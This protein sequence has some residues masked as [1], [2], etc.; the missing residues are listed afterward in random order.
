MHSKSGYIEISK[1]MHATMY[2]K[3]IKFQQK[4]LV[5]R[6]DATLRP[7]FTSGSNENLSYVTE[8]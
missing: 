5:I 8:N 7:N 6:H 2:L 4:Y 1:F 3:D